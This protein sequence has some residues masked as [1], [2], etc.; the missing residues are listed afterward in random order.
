MFLHDVQGL[1]LSSNWSSLSHQLSSAAVV[2]VVVVFIVIVVVV[3]RR[4][5]RVRGKSLHVFPRIITYAISRYV[6]PSGVHSYL[7]T[8]AIIPDH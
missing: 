7:S 2:V 8:R 4:L 6:V 3:A 1:F 5:K